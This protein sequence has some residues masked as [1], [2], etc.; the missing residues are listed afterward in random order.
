MFVIR[1]PRIQATLAVVAP[2][3][4]VLCV[5]HGSFY[6][7]FS[8][9]LLRQLQSRLAAHARTITD[10]LSQDGK[11]VFDRNAKEQARRR[12]REI[13]AAE[14]AITRI[15]LYRATNTDYD[16]PFMMEPSAEDGESSDLQAAGGSIHEASKEKVAPKSPF[17]LVRGLT[18]EESVAVKNCDTIVLSR[19]SS[20]LFV[21]IQG[22][23]ED[24]ALGIIRFE[25]NLAGVMTPV[26]DT[27]RLLAAIS[28]GM[29]GVALIAC[30]RMFATINVST[31]DACIDAIRQVFEHKNSNARVDPADVSPD[32]I[33]MADCLNEL[34]K[35]F[36]KLRCERDSN[37][38]RLET[39][40]KKLKE[41]QSDFHTRE[42]GFK[43][44]EREM[45]AYI[46]ALTQLFPYGVMLVTS[47]KRVLRANEQA[48]RLLRMP[49]PLSQATLSNGF[50]EI[51]SRYAVADR[52]DPVADYSYLHLDPVRNQI[53]AMRLRIVA[54]D[55]QGENHQMPRSFLVALVVQ[56][57]G[58]PQQQEVE[59]TL[60]HVVDQTASHYVRRGAEAA[61]DICRSVT[62]VGLANKAKIAYDSLETVS[63]LLRNA[64]CY[65]DLLDNE[66]QLQ[67]A[68]CDDIGAAIRL[69]AQ[70]GARHFQAANIDINCDAAAQHEQAYIPP[71][72]LQ[73]VVADA[74]TT[75][76]ALCPGGVLRVHVSRFDRY[77]ALVFS[78]RAATQDE[79]GAA[80]TLTAGSAAALLQRYRE[81]I[82][83]RAKLVNHAIVCCGGVAE[84]PQ[85]TSCAIEWSLKIMRRSSATPSRHAI[86]DV[87]HIVRS[88]ITAPS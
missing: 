64:C 26:R 67:R 48:I 19:H 80:C 41:Q 63:E 34:L 7:Y 62:D 71:R 49:T 74:V 13:M 73:L 55:C 16:N 15:I 18:S 24:R 44:R 2:L 75:L 86:A 70:D 61:R 6:W 76:L 84:G 77:V 88:V 22:A 12:A 17:S 11:L 72:L 1:S 39:A 57:A 85:P 23:R 50:W 52:N 4:F 8:N 29:L 37:A 38:Q 47:D 87:D 42:E 46:N 32:L 68:Y 30:L 51:I 56:G 54:L 53:I 3:S 35:R 27:L 28:F 36:V 59:H 9:D 20:C 33:A 10:V 21:P 65:V 14:P 40:N 83:L 78:L 69:G 43:L 58:N 31:R 5:L 25:Y 66:D 79:S 45:D 82:Q 60:I 81:W